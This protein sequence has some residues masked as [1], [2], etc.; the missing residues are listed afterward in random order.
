MNIF[1]NGAKRFVTPEDQRRYT[2]EVRLDQKPG[3]LP[4]VQN[5]GQPARNYLYSLPSKNIWKDKTGGVVETILYRIYVPDRGLDYAGGL[6]V[7]LR[8]RLG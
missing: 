1:R 3:D 6:P 4:L 2:V 5:A 7:A 8:I